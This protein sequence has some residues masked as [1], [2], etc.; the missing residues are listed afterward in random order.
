MSATRLIVGGYGLPG[1]LYAALARE[2]GGIVVP[3]GL[4]VGCGEVGAQKVLE[5]IDRVD[6]AVILIGHSRGGQLARVAACRRPA[7]VARLVSVAT[8]TSVGPPSR[9]GVL[10]V[11][12]ALR[13][14]PV[15]LAIDC[16]VA[17]CCTAFRSDLD[18]SVT[19]PWVAL[20]SPLDRV[21][22]PHEARHTGA[23]LV[24]ARMTHLG[25]VSTRAGRSAIVGAVAGETGRHRRSGSGSGTGDGSTGGPYVDRSG[26]R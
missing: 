25:F 21:V 24:V 8:P 7:R 3:T 14:L 10:L 20:W 18:A 17:P 11:S 4:T 2:L 23:E 12:A 5:A 22:P 13:L 15:D 9:R 6:G 26:N 16:A 19:V 1:K